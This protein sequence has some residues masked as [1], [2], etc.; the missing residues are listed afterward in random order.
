MLETTSA[1]R[2]N[3]QITQIIL[4]GG[5]IFIEQSFKLV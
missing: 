1:L 5:K 3:Y 2:G 4:F